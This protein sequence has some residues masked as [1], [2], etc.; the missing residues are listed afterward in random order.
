MAAALPVLAIGS[1][2]AATGFQ[3]AGS[4][5]QGQARADA[6]NYQAGVEKRK[7]AYGQI[8]ADQ[9]ASQMTDSLQN[10]LANIDAVRSAAGTA[11]DSP[12]G[13]ALRML[14]EALGERDINQ[15]HSNLLAQVTDDTDAAAFYRSSAGS[16]MNAA[17]LTAGGQ[18]LSGLSGGFKSFGG[19]G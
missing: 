3:M 17:E 2:L 13:A 15:K 8:K 9:T 5:A 18:L 16:A 12:T 19:F 11:P 14:S 10:T 1:S 7:A 6:M 4:M